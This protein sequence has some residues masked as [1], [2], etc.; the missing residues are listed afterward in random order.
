MHREL[1]ERVRLEQDLRLA[2]EREELLVDYQPLVDAD[3]GRVTGVEALVRW[4]HAALGL[5]APD[6]FIPI[7]EA[8]GL[9]AGIGAWVL[10]AA[11]E[12]MASWRADAAVDLEYVSVNVSAAQLADA[13]FP[14][15][16]ERTLAAAGLPASA[17]ALELTEAALVGESDCQL[18]V[19]SELAAIGVRLFLDDFGTGYS[20]LSSVRSLPVDALKVDRS[21]TA[22]VTRSEQAR[23]VLRAITEM[24]RALGLAV[25]A[26]GVETGGQL[27]VLRELGCSTV[28]GY[29]LGKPGSP[30]TLKSL[31]EARGPLPAFTP[32]AGAVLEPGC[33][34]DVRRMAEQSAPTYL[35]AAWARE[36]SAQ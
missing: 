3:S 32:S 11:C 28:Q 30:A 16:V 12:Q 27:A 13:G 2:V 9:I 5:V 6:T 4:K 20:S 22:D 31:L 14:A 8:T 10:A 19:L 1:V 15:L 33:R 36:A 26:E 23:Q 7:A 34:W 24:A 29:L 18:T 17:L 25:V 35:P 21:L